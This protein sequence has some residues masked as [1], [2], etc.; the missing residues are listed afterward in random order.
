MFLGSGFRALHAGVS[1]NMGT[2]LGSPYKPDYAILEYT[3]YVLSRYDL[4][5]NARVPRQDKS[6]SPKPLN[7]EP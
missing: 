1:G 4:T 7:H 6:H 5:L 3:V 2:C